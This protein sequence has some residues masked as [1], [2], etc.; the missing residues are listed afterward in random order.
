MAQQLQPAAPL[1]RNEALAFIIERIIR[2]GTSPSAGDIGRALQVSRTRA[3]QLTDQLIGER[4]LERTGPR[5]LAIRDL[6]HCRHIITE[7][8]RG[9]GLAVAEPMGEL[10]PPLSIS[11][12][13][14][15]PLIEENPAVH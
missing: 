7:T 12:L 6:V 13:P 9:L 1:R 8:L 2:T 11:Q 3:Q 5:T 4:V 15:L 14:L 10:Q